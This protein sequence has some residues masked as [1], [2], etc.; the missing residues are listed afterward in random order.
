MFSAVTPCIIQCIYIT[1]FFLCYFFYST[2]LIVFP[3]LFYTNKSFFG[4][5]VY[6]ISFERDQELVGRLY[7]FNRPLSVCSLIRKKIRT[8]I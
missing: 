7:M 5:F 6:I 2:I 3:L 4:T 8:F 1:M